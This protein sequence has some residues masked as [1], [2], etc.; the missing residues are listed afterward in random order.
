MQSIQTMVCN[1]EREASAAFERI[2]QT[3]LFNTRRVLDAFK[4]FQVAARHFAPTTGY[5]YDD[6]GTCPF[7]C[8]GCFCRVIIY[9]PQRECPTTPWRR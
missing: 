2:D 4:Q 5:G 8:S 9:Y 7:A 6:V 1:A 3:E